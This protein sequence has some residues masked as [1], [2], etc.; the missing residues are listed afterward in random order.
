M[1]WDSSYSFLF[2][3]F[4]HKILGGMA[5]STD[6]DQTATA[7]EG[8]VWSGSALFHIPVCQKRWFMKF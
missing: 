4:F 2:F 8:A 1:S 7:P 6:P 5:K 3:F